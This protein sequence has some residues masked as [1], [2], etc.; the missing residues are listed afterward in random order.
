MVK[1]PFYEHDVN[2][3]CP[4]FYRN[5]QGKNCMFNAVLCNS[6]NTFMNSKYTADSASSKLHIVFGRNIV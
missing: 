1:L 2:K 3:S 4:L 6:P 5:S